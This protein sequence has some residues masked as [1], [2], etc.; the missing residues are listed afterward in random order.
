MSFELQETFLVLKID[1][2]TPKRIFWVPKIEDLLLL[3][4]M[5]IRNFSV[6]FLGWNKTDNLN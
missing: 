3:K 2:F 6:D 5:R 4:K 1:I